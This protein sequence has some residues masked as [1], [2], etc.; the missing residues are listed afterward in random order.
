MKALTSFRKKVYTVVKRIPCGE[1]KSY[2]WVARKAG[3][4]GAAR[5]A[6]TALKNNPFVIIVPCH[7]VVR[8]DGSIGE[9][10]LGAGLKKKLLETEKYAGRN[11]DKIK[12][13]G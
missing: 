5:A 6:G 8:S 7:R 2:S 3:S 13:T 10:A 9:Y 1:T 4:P 12:R 11:K